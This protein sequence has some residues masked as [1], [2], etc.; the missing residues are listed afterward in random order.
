MK[1]LEIMPS[2]RAPEDNRPYRLVI[3]THD[4]SGTDYATICYLSEEAAREVA[5][6]GRPQIGWLFGEPDTLLEKVEEAS[7]Q[8]VK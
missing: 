3:R 5:Q 8:P 7:R 6:L 1:S 2:G 4:L